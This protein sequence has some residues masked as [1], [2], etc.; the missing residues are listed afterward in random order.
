MSC[1]AFHSSSSCTL[2][3]ASS[4]FDDDRPHNDGISSSTGG[5]GS[6]AQL[7]HRPSNDLK[8]CA[9]DTILYILLLTSL[10]PDK[11]CCSFLLI[12]VGLNFHLAFNLQIFRM[13]EIRKPDLF[14]NFIDGGTEI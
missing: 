9:R 14:D 5:S 3:I 11:P 10:E 12:K 2:W 13:N 8:N 6:D 7:A 1:H 4:I